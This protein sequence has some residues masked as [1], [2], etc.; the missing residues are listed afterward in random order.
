[1]L[2]VLKRFKVKPYTFTSIHQ[3][4]SIK[5]LGSENVIYLYR[6]RSYVLQNIKFRLILFRRTVKKI[7]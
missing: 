5:W 3:E 7:N 4:V 6:Y 2:Y 1:M